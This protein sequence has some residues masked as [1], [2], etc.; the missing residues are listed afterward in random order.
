M[1][2]HRISKNHDRNGKAFIK[3][4]RDRIG[5]PHHLTA[6]TE[7]TVDESNEVTYWGIAF[8][9]TLRR[10]EF[11]YST[12]TVAPSVEVEQITMPQDLADKAGFSTFQQTVEHYGDRAHETL[13]HEWFIHVE[14]A[15]EDMDDL[16]NEAA[17]Q[18]ENMLKQ[19]LGTPEQ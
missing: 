19:H 8:G 12:D 4:L 1:T 13:D 11:S 15:T 9:S 6:Y 10:L 16:V 5:W 14:T 17:E 7:A 18:L 2:T 3:A